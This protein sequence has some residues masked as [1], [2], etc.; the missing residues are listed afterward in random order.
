MKGNSMLSQANR[1]RFLK[2]ASFIVL[3]LAMAAMLIDYLLRGA[4]FHGGAFLHGAVTVFF[5]HWLL[6]EVLPTAGD[7]GT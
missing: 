6:F 3:P 5:I 4:T 2:S 7:K 1:L